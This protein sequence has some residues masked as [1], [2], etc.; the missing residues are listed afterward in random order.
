MLKFPFEQTPAFGEVTEVA[1]G[2]LWLRLPLPF[3]LD[4]VNM[5]LLEDGDGWAIVD[6]GIKTDEAKAIWKNVFAEKLAN[7]PI[8]RVIV[9]HF[10]PDH[11]GLAGWICNRFDIP[12]FTSLAT[13]MTNRL[14]SL[15]PRD[16]ESRVHFDFYTRHGM[17]PE[18]AGLVDLRGREYLSMV[19][20]PPESFMRLV[21]G[22]QLTIGKRTFRVF[23]FD[24]HAPEQVLLYCA[25]ESLLFAADHVMEKISPNVGVY[26]GDQKGDPLGHFVRSLQLLR[27]TIPEHVLV[28]PGH[29]R[30]FYGLHERCVELEQH[31]EDRCNLILQA[32]GERSQTIANLV[33]VLFKR[34]LDA[35]Q[36]A[37]AFAETLAH[38]HRLS[39]KSEVKEVTQNGRT[40][41][42]RV[43]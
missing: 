13:Y 42:C 4:H 7:T 19:E 21:Y 35:H 11:I 32:C 25:D 33:P 17:S 23:T 12:L 24:G 8:T 43:T 26:A 39:R 29:R 15:A 20:N 34:E 18:A 27:T 14:L 6:T 38:A 9:T 10:H 3:E 31:H 30:P 5:Y 40:Y 36:M 37:F 28:L 16:V 2:L 22:D 41:F 1:P